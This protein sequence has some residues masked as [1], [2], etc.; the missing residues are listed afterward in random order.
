MTSQGK[1]SQTVLWWLGWILLTILSFFVSCYFWTRFIARNVGT[2]HEP[3]VPAL[4]VTA[5][6]GSWM[7]LLVPLI[8]IMYNKVDK[9]YE[10]ARITRETTQ[11][12]KLKQEFQV[13]SVLVE[14]SARRLDKRLT[15]KL[16]G[17]PQ[18]IKRGHLV[19]A[20]LRDGRKVENVFIFDKRDVLGVYGLNELTFQPSAIVD[21]E[22]AD[23]DH[24]PP[25]QYEKWLRLDG[26]G[27]PLG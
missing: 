8:V 19:T 17:I 18:T 12:H 26:V 2:M 3:G 1:G 9:A 23:L 15:D 5:V 6:F 14:E 11:F 16:R 25:F 7:A 4:W 20:V 24:L 21:V 13:K 22:P 27:N 10:D